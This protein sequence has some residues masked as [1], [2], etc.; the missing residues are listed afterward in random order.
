MVDVKEGHKWKEE[1]KKWKTN[2]KIIY[3]NLAIS[4]ITLNRKRT[5]TPIKDKYNQN[6]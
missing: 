3:V 4:V 1:M 5:N 6:G 2:N